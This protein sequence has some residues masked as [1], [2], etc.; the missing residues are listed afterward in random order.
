MTILLAVFS[1]VNPVNHRQNAQSDRHKNSNTK[2]N[3]SSSQQ[4][5]NSQ[6]SGY[7][8]VSTVTNAKNVRIIS[9]INMQRKITGWSS[10]EQARKDQSASYQTKTTEVVINVRRVSNMNMRWKITC[11]PP[12]PYTS[13]TVRDTGNTQLSLNIAESVNIFSSLNKR[14]INTSW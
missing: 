3:W 12:N 11:R 6:S 8:T 1:E 14:R 10:S 9:N 4:A 5:G 13:S 2:H 7:Q